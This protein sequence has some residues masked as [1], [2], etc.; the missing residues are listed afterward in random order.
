[1][2]CTL[3]IQQSKR[4]DSS[5]QSGTDEAMKL[6]RRLSF[7]ADETITKLQTI[8][9]IPTTRK[10]LVRSVVKTETAYAVKIDKDHIHGV[11]IQAV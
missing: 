8:I 6:R 2:Q 10:D 7:P 3:I 4:T 5:T 9:N 1:M 11:N